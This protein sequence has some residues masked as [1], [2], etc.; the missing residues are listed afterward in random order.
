MNYIRCDNPGLF[1]FGAK[2]NPSFRADHAIL[3]VKKVGICGTDLHAFSGTQP[4]FSYPRILGHE[5][6][7]EIFSIGKNLQGLRAGDQVVLM[8]YINCQVCAACKAGKTNCCQEL[9]VFGVHVDGGMQE[10]ISFPA[11]LLI[12]ANDLSLDEI[13]ITEPLAIGAHALRRAQTKPGDTIVVMG[14]GPIGLGIIQLAK[15]IGAKVI[16]MD[17]NEHRL[18]SAKEQFGADLIIH[19]L[20]NPADQVK[21]YT[22]GEYANTVFDA[23]GSKQAIESGV[24]YMGHGGSY[25]LVGLYK[26]ELTFSHPAIHAKEITLMSSRNATQQD[27]LFVMQALREKKIN[28]S[29]Y[30]TK[31]VKAEAILNDFPAWS[32]PSSAEIKIVTE[33]GH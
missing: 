27:F 25:V 5:L 14:C 6:A 2:E 9:K 32:S 10:M 24:A 13:A 22:Q 11:R 31:R 16:A 17:I 18:R 28:T 15:Y 3:N 20:Q 1:S 7:T 30:I 12:K 21:D 8:P 33:W 19:A 4:Y 29:S 23:T 26:G